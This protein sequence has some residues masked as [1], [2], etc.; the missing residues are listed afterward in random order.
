[1]KYEIHIT[2]QDQTVSILDFLE[3][4][5]RLE[6][7]PI[8]ILL[9]SGE[10]H[11]MFSFK[12]DFASDQEATNWA[13]KMALTV[14][15]RYPLQRIKVEGMPDVTEAVYFEAHWKLKFPK[16]VEKADLLDRYCNR[17]NY[18]SN[19]S[20][21]YCGQVMWSRNGLKPDTFWLTTRN[22]N[23]MAFLK[24]FDH[25]NDRIN[26]DFGPSVVGFHKERVL[27]DTRQ[28]LDKNWI[29]DV[30]TKANSSYGSML[31]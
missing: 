12:Q 27:V 8:H 5:Y 30:T 9:S 14:M 22:P 26:K 7:T 20:L 16:F 13:T 25:F 23:Y 1:M 24:T 18:T 21:G 4:A 3:H 11:S 17:E 15:E 2:I 28:Q 6:A 19:Y 29:I 31:V 10:F